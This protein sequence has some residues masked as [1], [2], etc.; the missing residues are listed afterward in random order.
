VFGKS[1]VAAIAV[2]KSDFEKALSLMAYVHKE[3][4]FPGSNISPV[5]NIPR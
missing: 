5:E 1:D 2:G 3:L 4:F